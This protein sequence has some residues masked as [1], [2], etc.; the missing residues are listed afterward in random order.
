MKL[1]TRADIEVPLAQVFE[2]FANVEAWERAALRRG[3][4]VTRTASLPAPGVGMA[5]QARFD[6]RG[7]PRDLTVTVSAIEAPNRLAFDGTSKSV[8]GTL[9]VEFLEL[10][11]RRTRVKIST[12]IKPR[13]LSARLL[14]Q[15][16]KLA[17]TRIK[18][19][20]EARVTKLCAD[21]EDRHRA[22]PKR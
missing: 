9:T 18:T 12:E 13:T 17:K 5:W 2:D 21:I 11:A 1:S 8:D 15:S 6:Y 14:L 4:E 7:K 16:L 3:A 20:F 10:G 22:A 19:R